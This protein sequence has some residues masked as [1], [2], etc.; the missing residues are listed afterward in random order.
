LTSDPLI[1]QFTN[2]VVELGEASIATGNPIV[3]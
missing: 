2:D 1:L 3:F